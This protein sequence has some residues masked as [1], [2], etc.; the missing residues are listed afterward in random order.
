MW[1]LSHRSCAP[2]MTIIL[3]HYPQSP[4]AEKVRVVLGLKGLAWQSVIIPRLPPKPLLTPLT[5]GYRRTPVMQ[6]GADV[7][8]DSLCIIRELERRYPEPT[9]LPVGSGGSVTW[10]A[11]R[12]TDGEL[13]TH[14]IAVVLGSQLDGLA[15]EFATDRGR[16]YFGADHDLTQIAA[17]LPHRLGQLQAHLGWAE[18]Q[19]QITGRF[20]GGAEP[21]LLD[22][23]IYYIVWF[24]RGRCAQGPV[25]LSGFPH[26]ERWEITMADLGHGHPEEQTAEHAWEIAR[27][28]E[29]EVGAAPAANDPQKFTLGTLVQVVP[30][31]DG[32]DPPVQG[33]LQ[34]TDSRHGFDSPHPRNPRQRRHPFPSCGLPHHAPGVNRL[35]PRRQPTAS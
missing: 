33:P 2:L 32:G 21:G 27:V 30:D 12:W 31:V 24:L 10:G 13:F 15:P 5:G 17:E 14:A 4:V 26:L 9:L 25:L 7:F 19:L 8:C 22:A 35:H 3:H 6:I 23:L 34:G 18:S 28:A 29:P 20:L 16:L 11:A 1:V